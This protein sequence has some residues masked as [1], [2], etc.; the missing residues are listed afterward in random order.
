[1]STRTRLACHCSGLLLA[2]LLWARLSPGLAYAEE[3]SPPQSPATTPQASHADQPA[4]TAADPKAAADPKTAKPS[5]AEKHE[6][7]ADAAK[8]KGDGKGEASSK[9]AG[10]AKSAKQEKA[11][12]AADK[13]KPEAKATL[14]DAAQD[15]DFALQ[16]EFVGP[17]MT[18]PTKYQP[19]ALQVR[20]VGEG[21]FEAIQY[22]GGLPGE[23]AHRP[24]PITLIGKRSEQFLV[25]SGGPWAVFVEPDH[26]LLID[27]QGQRVGRL[28][29]VLRQSPT[30][31]AQP[32]QDAIILFDGK[33]THQFVKASMTDDGLLMEGAY[34]KPMLQDF[35]M[36]VEFMLPY[37]PA[38]KD[39]GRGN[40]GIYLQSRYE[41]QILDSFA[42]EPCFNGCGS[43]YRFRQPD[44]NMCLPPLV[45]QTY[46]IVFTAPR[47]AADDTKLSNARIT[48]WH[49]GVKVHNNAELQDKTGAGKPEEPTLLPTY[50]QD[51][52]NPVRFRNVW[53]VDRGLSTAASFPLF[54]KPTGEEGNKGDARTRAARGPNKDKPAAPRSPQVRPK[55]PAA[56]S[57]P[58][59]AKP[60][61]E[62]ANAAA[63]K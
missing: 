61:A 23:P 52:K 13:P 47:W 28:E 20:P 43:L 33:D 26:C 6:K 3:P 49:N 38:A 12:K 39:Q 9:A 63:S 1:M 24:E 15:P 57:Q 7:A 59:E 58:G 18:A 45:W 21:T 17:I 31:G 46:D 16:G 8:A 19:L 48:V 41:L 2:A 5:A 56:D 55:K 35:N 14:A 4:K 62:A 54:V 30:L 37:V 60:A 32:P 44:V 34:I 51:H 25:L 22:A 42:E 10:R 11:E 36:H 29:R 27:H 50:L 40:S 53:A